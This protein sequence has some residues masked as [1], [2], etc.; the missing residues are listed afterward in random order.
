MS[1][2]H[3]AVPCFFLPTH[4]ATDRNGG[5]LEQ[6]DVGSTSNSKGC[7]T[8]PSSLHEETKMWKADCR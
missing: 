4:T 1:C 2:F 6:D 5:S 7:S 8:N 3:G